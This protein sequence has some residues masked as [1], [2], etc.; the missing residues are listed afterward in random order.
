MRGNDAM[1]WFSWVVMIVGGIVII[2]MAMLRRQKIIEMAHRERMA[3]IER[4]MVP[5][6]THHGPV[7]LVPGGLHDRDTR[8]RMLSG[9]IV[10]IAFGLGLM[11][12]IGIAGDSPESAVGIGGAIAILGAA[13]VVIAMVQR[14]QPAPPLPP[15]S[16]PF[17]PPP[18]GSPHTPPPGVPRNHTDL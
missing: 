15:P 1:F 8:S 5:P 9:G 17:P 13:F 6:I 12:I 16:S 10:V 3:M 2:L 4:G 18:Y 11:M 14:N 7:A